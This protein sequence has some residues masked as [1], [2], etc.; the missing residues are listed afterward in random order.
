[1][2]A[3]LGF[4]Y[5]YLLTTIPVLI[6][7]A[8]HVWF[9]IRQDM[10]RKAEIISHYRLTE[11]KKNFEPTVKYDDIA[12]FTLFCLVPAFNLFSIV[13]IIGDIIEGLKDKPV[14]SNPFED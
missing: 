11:E 9:K 3:F 2:S 4:L 8:L 6:I 10:K 14:V 13:F 5:L 12:G 7:G 1:M